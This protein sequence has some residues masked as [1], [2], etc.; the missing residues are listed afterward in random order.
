MRDVAREIRIKF[1][2]YVVEKDKIDFTFDYK[3]LAESS[4]NRS[5]VS[6]RYAAVPRTKWRVKYEFN[7]GT[8]VVYADSDILNFLDSIKEIIW[9]NTEIT[10]SKR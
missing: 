7:N 9:Q 10:L 3:S 5:F 4:K 2:T 1:Y 6:M 8:V